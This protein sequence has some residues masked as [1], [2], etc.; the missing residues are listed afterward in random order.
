MNFGRAIGMRARTEKSACAVDG[1][2]RETEPASAKGLVELP[3]DVVRQIQH[4]LGSASQRKEQKR[5][6]C[7]MRN[8]ARHAL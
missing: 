6:A 2:V 8:P 1:S 3:R 4:K 5:A 7:S